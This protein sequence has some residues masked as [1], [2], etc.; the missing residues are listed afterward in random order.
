M[1]TATASRP[2][3]R[4]DLV[5]EPIDEEG[6]RFID[7]IDPDTGSAFRFYEVEYSLACAMDGER[8]VAGLASWAEEELGITPTSSELGS[9]IATLGDLGYLETGAAQPAATEVA[10]GP[11][12]V[13]PSTPPRPTAHDVELGSAGFDGGDPEPVTRVDDIPLGVAGAGAAQTAAARARQVDLGPAGASMRPEPSK[14]PV[15]G[16]EVDLSADLSVGAD[17]VKEAVRASKVMKAAEIPPDLAAV[18]DSHEEPAPLPPKMPVFEPPPPRPAAPPVVQAPV[19]PPPVA[20]PVEPPRP[21]KGPTRPPVELGA[22]PPTAKHAAPPLDTGAQRTSPVLLVLLVLV[23]LGA[24]GFAFWKYYWVPRHKPAGTAPVPTHAGGTGA[25]SAAV[26]PP[27]PPP[28]LTAALAMSTPASIDVQSPLAGAIA[29]IAADGA[30]VNQGDEIARIAGADKALGLVKD[31]QRT[32][33]SIQAQI[34]KLTAKRDAATGAAQTKLDEQVQE[35]QASLAKKQEEQ[36]A[37][38]AELGKYVIR[39]PATGALTISTARGKKVAAND[40]VATLQPVGAPTATF[41][42]RAGQAFTPEQD[43]TLKLDGTGE[44]TLDCKVTEVSGQ[45]LVVQC[46]SEGAPPDGTKVILVDG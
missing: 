28:P 4:T 3:F 7:V 42:L 17:D 35:R 22:I 37:L 9:V 23:I 30:A 24:G 43:V 18:L 19:P 21:V 5:A 29:S 38:E 14:T 45:K 2:R 1:E 15:G 13:V 46:A 36:A 26:P 8:D 34:D 27:P 20:R 16:I 33:A 40:V 32:A 12:V 10:V 6:Q 31:A 11:G 44:A 39:A 41:E 25:G